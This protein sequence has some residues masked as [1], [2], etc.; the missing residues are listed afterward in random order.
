MLDATRVNS[1]HVSSGVQTAGPTYGVAQAIVDAVHQRFVQLH[2]HYSGDRGASLRFERALLTGNADPS[3]RNSRLSRKYSWRLFLTTC[4]ASQRKQSL[5]APTCAWLCPFFRTPSRVETSDP[6][7]DNEST[8]VTNL[9]S[10][11]GPY[12]SERLGAVLVHGNVALGA[13]FPGR[14]NLGI[15][16]C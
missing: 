8:A 1:V 2:Q 15:G 11:T 7:S 16:W 4:A 9:L 3:L 14:S 10:K 5:L 13:Q 12:L 6:C